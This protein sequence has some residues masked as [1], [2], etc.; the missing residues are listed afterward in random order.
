MNDHVLDFVFAVPLAPKA[1][2]LKSLISLLLLLLQELALF[3]H[4]QSWAQ[5]IYFI[6]KHSCLIKSFSCLSLGEA[7][8]ISM[9]LLSED[10]ERAQ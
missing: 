9:V 4:L 8:L 10:L 6:K 2:K 7:I 5:T 1:L 3:F